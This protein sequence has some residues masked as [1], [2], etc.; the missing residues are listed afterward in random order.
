[1]F[2]I[3]KDN[4]AFYLT[5]VTKDRLPIFRTDS[6]AQ[7]M[8]NALNEARRSGKFLIFAYVIMLDHFHLVTESKVDSKDILRFIKG[9]GSRRII[10]HLKE[11]GNTESLK[12]LR[13]QRRSDGSDYMVWQ[14][15]PNTRLLWSEQMLWQ[16][17]QY[18]HLNPVR[19]GLV[20][21]PNDWR[22]SSAR[23]WCGRG[24]DVEPLQLDSGK[25][26]WHH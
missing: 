2:R 25:I 17:I 7:L 14:R 16:R 15:H 24:L 18:T 26:E 3:S 8:C 23:I 21:Y 5:A 20:D 19:A 11:N 12:K 1:M 4:P 10:D 9:I 13:V 6:L 22:W